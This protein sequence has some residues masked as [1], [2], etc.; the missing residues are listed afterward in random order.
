MEKYFFVI[1]KSDDF[2]F[3]CEFE[4]AF[5]SNKPLTNACG[6]LMDAEAVPLDVE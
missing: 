2:S 5:W 6:H 1:R 3:S 4:D